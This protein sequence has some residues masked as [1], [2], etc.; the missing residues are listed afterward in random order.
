MSRR[1]EPRQRVEITFGEDTLGVD[2][3]MRIMGMFGQI[4]LRQLGTLGVQDL[5]RRMR[6]NPPRVLSSNAN[7]YSTYTIAD[8]PSS[9]VNGLVFLAALAVAA[10]EEVS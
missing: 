8:S 3:P 7:A 1:A 2:F 6:F 4:L 9:R 5:L 10:D